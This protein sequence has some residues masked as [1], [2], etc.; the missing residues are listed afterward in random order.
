MPGSLSQFIERSSVPSAASFLEYTRF[1]RSEDAPWMHS[2]NLTRL[3]KVVTF[4][5]IYSYCLLGRAF[6]SNAVYVDFFLLGDAKRFW[7]P[8]SRLA[9]VAESGI[10]LGWQRVCKEAA[11]ISDFGS[12]SGLL[13]C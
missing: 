8:G 9:D 4:Y 10:L 12:Y 1:G 3:A 11:W 2:C 6:R 7:S 5:F 13:L